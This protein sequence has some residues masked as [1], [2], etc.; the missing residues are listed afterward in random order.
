MVFQALQKSTEIRN[1]GQET[2]P[3][4]RTDYDKLSKQ[5]E[6]CRFLSYAIQCLDGISENYS[7]EMAREDIKRDMV[8]MRKHVGDQE[9]WV[10]KLLFKKVMDLIWGRE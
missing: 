8:K 6:V 4:P 9:K 7:A 1:V 3:L 5:G 10:P 2:L